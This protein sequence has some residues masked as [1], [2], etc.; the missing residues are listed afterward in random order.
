MIKTYLTIGVA[1]TTIVTILGYDG[2]KKDRKFDAI[3]LIACTI[4]YIS[5]VVFWPWYMYC[6]WKKAKK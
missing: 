3:D 6:G 2:C 4:V 1:L 5:S